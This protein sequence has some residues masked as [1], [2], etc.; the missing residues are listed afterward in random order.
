MLRFSLLGRIVIK[1]T[2]WGAL[3][4]VGYEMPKE[5]N[6]LAASTR[7][8]SVT[9]KT[10][11]GQ[12]RHDLRRGPQ[13]KYV[14]SDRG[15]LNRVLIQPLPPGQMRK[16]C[17]ERRALRDTSRAMKSNAAI[18]TRG[19]ITFG[20]EASRLFERLSPDQQDAA[21]REVAQAVADRLATSLHGLV[22]HLDEATIHAHYQ[23]AAYNVHGNPI[24]K[25][26]SPRVLSELQDITAEA[27]AR[28]CPG[29]ERGNRYGDRIAAG[30]NFADTLHISVAELHR[31]LPADL[32]KK[33]EALA[34]LAKAE[35][36]AAARFDEMWERVQKLQQKTELSEKE[37]KRLETYEKRLADRLN[38]LREAQSASEAARI[39]A[40]RLADLARADRQQHEEQVVKISAKVEAIAEAVSAL[41]EEV[42]AGTIRR[43]ND[44]RITA[45]KP[46]RL[47][48]GFPEIR[49]A[50]AAAADLVTGM[51]AARS[52][53]EAD[54]KALAR[55]RQEL[56]EARAEVAT[57]R[58][59]LKA[60]LRKVYAWIK[61]KE[62]LEP[63][64]RD[65]I[66]LINANT[67]LIR[68]ATEK[69]RPEAGSD[70]GSPGF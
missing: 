3:W 44:D 41:S 32:A 17:Q 2:P 30:A 6:P 23:L 37:V 69:S 22:V 60:A 70:L 62:T 45:A 27:M 68:S 7:I 49:P 59:N 63:D 33:R 16:I 52:A 56:Q 54:R 42:E 47:K 48:P 26:T 67:P 50:V 12:I 40:E 20:A 66:D 25:T 24:A 65:G 8:G 4:L 38:E 5:S 36:E 34:D 11:S 57:L 58:E 29:I 46:E 39:E 35:T 18:G 19:V 14:A 55:G 28:H 43:L 64:R 61:R 1:A 15:H 9:A 51:D 53:I 10:L 13:P 21:F 31:T